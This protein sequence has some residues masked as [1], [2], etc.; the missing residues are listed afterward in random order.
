MDVRDREMWVGTD[1]DGQVCL[2]VYRELNI[3][4]WRVSN[5]VDEDYLKKL[6]EGYS[7]YRL[8]KGSMDFFEVYD[9]GNQ[10]RGE[11]NNMKELDN[12]LDMLNNPL[13]SFL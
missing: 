11:F 5:D 7:A 2:K 10:P 13:G 12:L 3:D 9:E 6:P 8:R 4:G 1:K